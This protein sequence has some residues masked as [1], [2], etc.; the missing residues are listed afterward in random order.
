MKLEHVYFVAEVSIVTGQLSLYTSQCFDSATMAERQK[1]HLQELFPKT[2][3]QVRRLD[4]QA[5]AA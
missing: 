2:S 4:V 1:S 5:G 3:F